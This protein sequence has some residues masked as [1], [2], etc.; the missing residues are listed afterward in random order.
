M[1]YRIA[2]LSAALL[3]GTSAAAYAASA[4]MI[5]PDGK[6]MGTLE[7][8][9][10]SGGVQ[11]SGSISGLTPGEHAFHI[12]E[13]GKCEAPFT[14]SGG[15]YN[16]LGNK[17]GKVEGGSHAG[18][19]PNLTAGADGMVKISVVNAGVTL[20]KGEKNSVFDG[21]GSAFIIHAKADDY[22][23][24]PTGDAGGRVACGVI[25]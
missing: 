22:T 9:E 12:H 7:L 25:Q 13:T 17:H 23:T 8:T 10:A 1:S 4:K 6:D 5:G 20:K 19:M 11:I 18:D 16:P 14:S 24:Q 21:D 15:H 2:L 3:L